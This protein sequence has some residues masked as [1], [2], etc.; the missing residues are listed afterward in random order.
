MPI[1]EIPSTDLRLK[2]SVWVNGDG[3]LGIS[4]V[5]FKSFLSPSFF[6]SSDATAAGVASKYRVYMGFDVGNDRLDG[7]MV[8]IVWLSEW[9]NGIDKKH[10]FAKK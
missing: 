9:Y 8:E 4:Y 3:I 5:F 2:L 10:I 1:I 7:F 6:E